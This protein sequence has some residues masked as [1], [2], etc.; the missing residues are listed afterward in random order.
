MKKY[1]D[2]IGAN[3]TDSAIN[4]RIAARDTIRDVYDDPEKAKEAA[5]AYVILSNEREKKK[6]DSMT[7]EEYKYD[8]TLPYL[9]K[10]ESVLSEVSSQLYAVKARREEMVR[11]SLGRMIGGFAGF[12][13]LVAVTVV[14]A[15][16]HLG[17]IVFVFPATALGS[18]GIGISGL[19]EYVKLKKN[20]K[21]FLA[22][23]AWE[24]VELPH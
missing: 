1:Y 19:S 3:P 15:F 17:F 13:A 4:I 22:Y 21:K 23:G 9:R 7:D 20:T 10:P 24:Y 12:L 14:T 8:E 16:I 11:A 6:Y 18:V 5:I 2:L